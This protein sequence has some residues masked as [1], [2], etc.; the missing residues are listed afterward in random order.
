MPIGCMVEK[1][2]TPVVRNSR[3]KE[4]MREGCAPYRPRQAERPGRGCLVTPLDS[5]A[6][7]RLQIEI[8]HQS[9]QILGM[10]AEQKCWPFTFVHQKHE[11]GFSDA[12]RISVF[13]EF[14]SYRNSIHKSAVVVDNL[15]RF[16]KVTICRS[17]LRRGR[18]RLG[19][20]RVPS[21]GSTSVIC[22]LFKHLTH[23]CACRE[24]SML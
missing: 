20:I 11:F 14:A 5:S 10:N 6:Q 9:V 16:Q 19:K 21:S 24:A 4:Y 17:V 1:L 15:N 18:A 23:D 7:L 2:L 8:P 13:D 3:L 12:D 22:E